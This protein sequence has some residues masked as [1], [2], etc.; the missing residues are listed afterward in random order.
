MIRVELYEGARVIAGVAETEVDAATLGGALTALA[1]KYPALEP[2]VIESGRLARHW[3]ASINGRRFVDDPET[4]LK[5]GDAIVIVSA[6]AG[7]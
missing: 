1:R 3:R 4:S 5:D 6:L 2:R 7:G